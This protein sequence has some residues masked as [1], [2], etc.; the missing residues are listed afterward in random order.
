M[1]I[2]LVQEKKVRNTQ[3]IMLYTFPRKVWLAEVYLPTD[4]EGI[5]LK[6]NLNKIHAAGKNVKMTKEYTTLQDHKFLRTLHLRRGGSQGRE[7]AYLLVMKAGLLSIFSSNNW[8]PTS[9]LLHFLTNH[10]KTELLWKD[11]GF[12]LPRSYSALE[13]LQSR[14]LYK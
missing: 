11:S 4:K 10:H 9:S 12:F 14:G 3:R 8:P 6:I 13:V 5:L 1:A 7:R 2:I